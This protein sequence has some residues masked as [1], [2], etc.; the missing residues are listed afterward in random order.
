[1]LLPPSHAAAAAL[2]LFPPPFYGPQSLPVSMML[3]TSAQSQI[4]DNSDVETEDEETR[5]LDGT[6]AAKGC[7][8]SK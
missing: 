7:V 6:L 3:P 5:K 8:V 4:E 1:M 2:G